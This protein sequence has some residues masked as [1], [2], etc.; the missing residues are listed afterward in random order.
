MKLPTEAKRAIFDAL[1]TDLG[2]HGILQLDR[3]EG[4][5]YTCRAPPNAKEMAEEAARNA[6]PK[7]LDE[8]RR[9]AVAP[10]NEFMSF[11]TALVRAVSAFTRTDLVSLPPDSPHRNLIERV[12]G[13]PH[14]D[15]MTSLLTLRFETL[16]PASNSLG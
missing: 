2:A 16:H 7:S 15:A 14:R 5:E 3:P 9:R 11:E 6:T 4:P 12:W 10:D 13:T 8:L 1:R